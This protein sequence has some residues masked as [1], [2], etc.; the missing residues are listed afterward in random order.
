MTEAQQNTNKCSKL[1]T[2]DKPSR[3]KKS[4]VTH[5]YRIFKD[6]SLHPDSN[7][8]NF[9]PLHCTESPEPQTAVAANPIPVL[10][11]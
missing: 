7:H 9:T 6:L 3:L 2:A 5:V 10:V 1:V 8:A 4:R 11:S